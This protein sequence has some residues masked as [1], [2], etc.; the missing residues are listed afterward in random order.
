[1][2][3][4]DLYVRFI[5]R[6]LAGSDA[7][8]QMSLIGLFAGTITGAIIVLFR[9]AI[10]IPLYYLIPDQHPEH[11]ETLSRFQQATLPIAG[12]LVIGLFLY[13]MHISIRKVGVVHVLDR[14]NNHQGYI[15]FKSLMVQ[16]ATGVLTLV[17]G[18]SAGRE[19]PVVHLG[20]A[21]GSLLGQYMKL[22]NNSIRTLIACGT[23]AAISAS[24]NTPIAGVIFAMEVVMMDFAIASFTPVIVA[25]VSA[26]IITQTV[27][28]SEPAFIV[29][30]FALN[31]LSEIPFVILT[32]LVI[33]MASA[34]FVYLI[35]AHMRYSHRNII[36]RIM[37]AGLVTGAAAFFYP[38]IMGIGYDTVNQVITNE[39]ALSVLVSVAVVKL[40]VTAISIGLGMPS[41]I[42]GPI[43]FIGATIGGACGMVTHLIWPGIPS[44]IGFYAMIGM[45]S[46]MGACLHAPLSAL[47]TLLEL[48][49]NPNIILPAMLTIVVSGIIS[50]G[51][52]RQKSVFLTMLEA[53]GLNFR[54]DP[55]I[56]ALQRVSVGAVME[57]NQKRANKVISFSDAEKLLAAEPE[58]IV[59]EVDGTPKSL[60]PAAD[61]VRYMLE[62][63]NA[64]P[65]QEID[66][67]DIPAQRKEIHS[68]YFQATLK[69]ALDRFHETGAEALYV[70][71]TTAPLITTVLGIIT[72]QDIDRYYH[73]KK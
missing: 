48:T 4:F 21:C 14:V 69:E 28:G 43:L 27:Y 10:E 53:Q 26:A 33:G 5:R 49:Q 16:F 29:P 39:I 40:L 37:V 51:I 23:A 55:V 68:I 2:R 50:E 62:P 42:I 19:G 47:L 30:Q 46:M 32:G 15:S 20:S 1:M 70:E 11:F 22:P 13:A 18:Q 58:W 56:N 24:F 64:D 60:L 57:R 59:I 25:S 73:Y 9:H 17:S 45:A 34:L 44:S 63:D 61:L 67:L 52:F 31:S 54:N 35:K 41:G 38:Q 3:L 6:P 65:E 72:R 66:L 8:L 12:A 36:L 71:R 7:L